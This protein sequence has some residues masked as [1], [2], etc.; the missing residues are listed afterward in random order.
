M[1]C[2]KPAPAY[3]CLWGFGLALC[4]FG[5]VNADHTRHPQELVFGVLPMMSTVAL[6]KRFAPLRDYLSQQLGMPV[7]IETA[8]NFTEYVRRTTQR[9]YDVVFTAPHMVVSALDSHR[10]ELSATLAEPLQTV[11]VVAETSPVHD[12]AQLQ[13]KTIAT[14]PKQAIVTIMGTAYLKLHGI[15]P[16]GYLAYRSHNAATSAALGGDAS[17]AM[18]ANFIYL[19]EKRHHKPLRMI[20]GSETFPS[21]GVVVATDLPDGLKQMITHAFVSMGQTEYGKAV[22]KKI[23]Q[24]GY[25]PAIPSDFEILR[26]Y[27]KVI[28]D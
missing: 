13:D 14:P 28:T 15:V 16:Q 20:A 1:H 24:P 8:K 3:I 9:Q 10:Y 21:A 27:A 4:L 19:K 23:G 6:F 11:I 12:I 5:T 25:K 17:A 22:L 2:V 18:V 26:P 7:K